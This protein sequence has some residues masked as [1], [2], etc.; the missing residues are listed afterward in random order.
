[1]NRE[2]G[3]IVLFRVLAGVHLALG[4]RYL[5]WRT[6]E[7]FNSEAAVLSGLF[8]AAELF[9]FAGAI[10]F[11]CSQ[12]QWPQPAARVYAALEQSLIEVP[13]IDVFVLCDRA[14]VAEAQ[15]TAWAALDLDYPWHRLFVYIVDCSSDTT[16]RS[17]AQ[18]VPCDYIACPKERRQAL[19]YLLR[20]LSTFGEFLL[21]LEAGQIPAPDIL[22]QMLPNFYDTPTRAPIAN[23]TGFVQAR[24]VMAGRRD[25]LPLQQ[26]LAVGVSGNQ[27]AP[28]LGSG[29]LLRRCA[30]AALP[31]IDTSDPVRLGAELHIR[32]WRSHLSR[33]ASISTERSPLR[34]RLTS[35]LTLFPALRLLPWWHV[36]LSQR[37]R[38]QYL[39]L[40]WWSL[41]G[42]AWAVY[43]FVPAWF[44]ATGQTPV[45]H[46]DMTFL[47]WFLPYAVSG[48]LAWLAAFPPHLWGAAWQSE[49]Q[50][51]VE[52]FSS[53]QAI[54]LGWRG[55]RSGGPT[56]FCWR[57]G[58]Q[59]ATLLLTA[60]AIAIG[61]VRLGQEGYQSPLAIAIGG[62]WT[63][64]NLLLLAVVP[65]DG[66]CSQP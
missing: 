41:G 60:I 10:A 54:L 49:R 9:A 26:P 5:Y 57:V 7:G 63:A 47:E 37:Q 15:R 55:K 62:I 20:E 25:C 42:W 45:P 61:I 16:L 52:W 28:L 43:L 17:T 58:A 2:V 32:G 33:T 30:L 8:L 51:W 50:M 22:Q 66:R 6:T 11:S 13:Y 1:V 36:P 4:V 65:I 64:Y 44:L 3:Q 21:L 23:N 35:L 56:A 29:G 40:C 53:L 19:D 38:Y 24:L 46:F 34:D 27:T 48:R 12:E 39:W 18:A 31:Q 14:T 59:L